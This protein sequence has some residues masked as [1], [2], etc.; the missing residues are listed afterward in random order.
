MVQFWMNNDG[1]PIQFGPD[2]TRPDLGGDYVMFGPNRVFETFINLGATAFGT[3][4]FQNPSLPSSFVG[5][6][7][8]TAGIVSQTSLFPLQPVAPVT[9][10]NAS[11]VLTLTNPQL[12]IDAVE[13]EVLVT[14]NAGA[15]GA[16]GLTG[17]GLASINPT[18]SLFVQ[19]TPNPGVQLVGAA[20]IANIVTGKKWL[21]TS[22]GVAYGSSNPPTAGSWL[23]NVPLVTNVISPLPTHGYVSAIA[24]GGTFTGA[25]GGGLLKLR[26]FYNYYGAINQ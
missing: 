23:G 1:V 10:A 14:A 2:K 3:G 15:G 26:V 13:L 25:S 6:N 8:S 5:T 16:T 17:I 24:S 19:T 21:W 7:F 9:V 22:D 11:G 12:W 20:A 18:T 4:S